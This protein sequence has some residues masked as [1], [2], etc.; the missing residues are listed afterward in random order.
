MG[1]SRTRNAFGLCS[2]NLSNGSDERWSPWVSVLVRSFLPGLEF[3]PICYC[4][5][6][7]EYF[8][9]TKVHCVARDVN[10]KIY[11]R[12]PPHMR[13]LFVFALFVYS[14]S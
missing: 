3:E 4:S 9:F 10:G 6:Y 12:A 14:Y 1:I 11:Y 5:V 7:M 8:P 13:I 2:Y